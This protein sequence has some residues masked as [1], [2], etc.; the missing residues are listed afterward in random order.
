MLP[1]KINQHQLIIDPDRHDLDYDQA[2]TSLDTRTIRGPYAI[3]YN[4]LEE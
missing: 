4:P 2:L 3:D 1:S